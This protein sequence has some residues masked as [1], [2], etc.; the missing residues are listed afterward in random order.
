MIQQLLKLF[1]GLPLILIGLFAALLSIIGIAIDDTA[2][3]RGMGIAL[4]IF[5][6]VLLVVGVRIFRMPILTSP[7]MTLR[8]LFGLVSR[9]LL[10]LFVLCLALFAIVPVSLDGT[11]EGWGLFIVVALVVVL[12][13]VVRAY[14]KATLASTRET[15]AT[16]RSSKAKPNPAPSEF[17]WRYEPA[18]EE[19]KDYAQKLGLVFE[20]DIL[21]GELSDMISDAKGEPRFQGGSVTV[22]EKRKRDKQ[23]AREN[24]RWAKENIK[25]MRQA[26]RDYGDEGLY[27]GFMFVRIPDEKPSPTEEPYVGSFLPLQVAEKYPDLLAVETIEYEDVETNQ[28][29]RRG[30]KMVIKPGKFKK[31]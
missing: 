23:Q 18:S 13:V 2:E 16:S 22:A 6:L 5:A 20:D 19:Q 31:L 29:L 9:A 27:A 4:A 30:T 15:P 8:W 17:A 24:L 21:R 1:L 7:A 12:V 25:F 3:G 26:N 10:F 14:S 28:R 11:A